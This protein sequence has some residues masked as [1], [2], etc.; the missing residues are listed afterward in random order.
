LHA[1]LATYPPKALEMFGGAVTVPSYDGPI[2]HEGNDPIDAEFGQLLDDQLG[3][4]PFDQREPDGEQRPG[5]GDGGDGTGHL[6]RRTETARPP[7]T[8]TIGHGQSIAVAHAQHPRQVVAVLVVEH[9]HVEIDN[10]RVGSRLVARH[11]GHGL[12]PARLLDR[13]TIDRSAT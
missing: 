8:G 9:G 10:E 5:P 12:V 7:T 6:E 3:P 4:F 2:S 13:S 1:C 11:V